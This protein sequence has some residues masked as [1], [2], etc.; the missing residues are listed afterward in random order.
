MARLL[1]ILFSGRR[2]GY[3]A[4]LLERAVKGA[5]SVEGVEVKLIQNSNYRY[6]PCISCFYCIRDPEHTCSLDDD[7]G[8]KGEGALFKELKNAN[9]LI[10]AD[11]VHFWGMSSGCHLFMERCYPFAW[12]DSLNGM[13][14]ASISCASN[15]GMQM[16]ATR[17]ICKFAFCLR[18]RY[19]G[20]LPVHTAYFEDALEEAEVLGRRVAEAALK[21]AVEGR[22]KMSDYERWNYY[23]NKPWSPLEL[24]FE[25]LTRGTFR[26]EDSLIEYGLRHQTFKREEAIELLKKSSEEL[27]KALRAYRLKDYKEAMKLLLSASAYWTHATWKEFLEEEAIKAKIPE[28]YRPISE[29]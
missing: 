29:E 25:N 5:E 8:R 18:L 3:T 24:Y 10:I 2:K 20:G 4:T 21:D 26:W 7:F 27:A 14:F 13:P 17:D 16:I 22:K 1:A 6:S 11:P 15:Q 28:V 12:S 19:I 9:G 23:M